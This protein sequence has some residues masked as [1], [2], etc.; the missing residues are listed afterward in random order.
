[1]FVPNSLSYLIE[2]TMKQS[3]STPAAVTLSHSP[4]KVH[5]MSWVLYL[6]SL[7]QVEQPTNNILDQLVPD[8]SNY[9]LPQVY[10]V[11]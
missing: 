10:M 4:R 6:R 8:V 1:M 3:T 2:Q 5:V 11:I 7:F 9:L